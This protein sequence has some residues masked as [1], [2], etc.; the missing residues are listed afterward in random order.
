M[1]IRAR[2]ERLMLGDWENSLINSA[3][4]SSLLEDR[5]KHYPLRSKR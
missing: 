4:D 3:A 5:I 1:N 2:M